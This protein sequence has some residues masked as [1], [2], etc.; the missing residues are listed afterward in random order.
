EGDL[1]DRAAFAEVFDF[2]IGG[3]AALHDA[4]LRNVEGRLH[5]PGLG[6][7]DSLDMLE[8]L[9]VVG[10]DGNPSAGRQG[11]AGRL[12]EGGLNESPAV[13]ALLGPGVRVVDVQEVQAPGRDV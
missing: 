8:V 6:P 5:Q 10:L 2:E 12:D 9:G 7:E 4:G 13:V 1:V 3:D 11:G